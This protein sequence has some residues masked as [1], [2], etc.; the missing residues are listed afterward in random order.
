MDAFQEVE[1]IGA[2]L[3]GLL[4]DFRLWSDAGVEAQALLLEGVSS[5]VCW[6]RSCFLLLLVV[7]LP[8]FSFYSCVCDSILC[9]VNVRLGGTFHGIAYALV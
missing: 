6:G 1:L 3:Q 4:L 9:F 5:V 8:V 7:W 2:A